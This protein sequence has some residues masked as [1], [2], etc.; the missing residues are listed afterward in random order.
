MKTK[1]E[2]LILNGWE[3]M[4]GFCFNTCGAEDEMLTF[5]EK[6]EVERVYKEG[7]K[8]YYWNE[9][10]EQLYEL[11]DAWEIFAS[12]YLEDN[13]LDEDYDYVFKQFQN[14]VKDK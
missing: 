6:E 10:K 9:N 11:D 13:E 2:I 3:E 14:E 8:K 7:V 4:E 5:V 1:E 12:D